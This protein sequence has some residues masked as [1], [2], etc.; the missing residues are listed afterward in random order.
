MGLLSAVVAG[1]EE[2]TSRSWHS[3]EGLPYNIVRSLAQTRDG[4]LWVGTFAGLAR[5]DGVRFTT[6]DSHNT[7]ALKS[8]NISALCTD[9]DGTLWIG[10]YGGGI[11]RLKDGVFTAFGAQ[12]GLIGEY[13]SSL[14]AARD[15]TIWIGTTKGVNRLRG[16]KF[17]HYGTNEGLGADIVRSILADSAGNVWI[18][19]GVGLYRLRGEVMDSFTIRNG[20]PHNSVRGLMQDRQGVLW[21]GSDAGMT[22]YDGKTFRTYGPAEG[23]TA[24]FV[25]NFC[26][27]QRGN[28][29]IGT[30][31]GTVRFK[32]GKFHDELS[33]DKEPFD[34][35][36]TLFED[37]EGDVWAGSREGLIRFIPKR[38]S[39]FTRREGLSDNNVLSVEEDRQGAVWAGTWGG[40]LDQLVDGTVVKNYS[41][42]NGYPQDLILSTCEARDGS[43]W[44]GADYDTGLVHIENGNITHYTA[45]NGLFNAAVRVLRE[46]KSGDLWI[47]T[48]QGLN[49]LH[50]GK[51][52]KYTVARNNLAGPVVRDICIDSKDRL[53]IA[54]E[55]GLSL[56]ENG[57]CTNFTTSN[58]LVSA[59]LLSV[60]EDTNGDL[61]L[62]SYGGGLE[63][64]HNGQFTS[65]AT[66][67]GM[68][69]DNAF[70]EAEDDGGNLW[71]SCTRGIV[72]VRKSDF[73]A[74]DRHQIPALRTVTY[75]R[76][77]GL[78]GLVC[79]N[80]SQPSVWKCRD[81]RILFPS[82]K[83]LVTVDA[84][85]PPNALPPPVVIEQLI[86]DNK[87][88]DLVAPSP[89]GPGAIPA[90]GPG[91]AVRIPPGRGGVEIHFTA[92]S[93]QLSEK[94]N[95][96][97]QL[98]GVDSGWVDAGTR[99]VAYYNN[100]APGNYQF[101]VTACNNDGVWSETP[102]T[103]SFE[104][105]P[106]LWQTPWFRVLA[107]VVLMGSVAGVVRYVS[108][109]KLQRQLAALEGQHA[110]EKERARIAR[111]IHD[112]LGA[113]LTQI[114]LLSD[115]VGE[116]PPDEAR[117][118]ARKISTTARDLAQSLDE[119]VWAVNPRHDTLEGLVE[120]ISQFSDDFLEDT[121]I[122]SR[123]KLPGRL[124]PC[125]IPAEARHQFFL[126]FKEALH[127]AV[128]HS[129]ATE[130]EI[131]ASA[132]GAEMQL[133]IIDNGAGFDPAALNGRGNGLKN[134]RQRL[135]RIGGRFNLASQPGQGTRITLAIRVN[136]APP[137]PL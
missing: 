88:M 98:D 104:L 7:P 39:T 10:T 4:Y 116:E 105:T 128:K 101:R 130:I 85:I 76:L 71:I 11:T 62:G 2:F 75:G 29:W 118:S 54:T 127:N 125:S 112:D 120:Y 55:D 32:D 131:A 122:R 65:Y 24:R 103:L 21:I 14:S 46:D 64:R 49:R 106:H 19:T 51:F 97:Y 121:A 73:D 133:Q 34:L 52:S 17:T 36:N 1:A 124:P 8:S 90:T 25:Q 6:F 20:L 80:T 41:S 23:L 109:R 3:D 107:A 83:G 31:S 44:V 59:Y 63:R 82:T 47:G 40:G 15:G 30:Y 45:K 53:W 96:K 114:A 37:R 72:R 79:N 81:G 132:D 126:A 111:D 42:R 9:G 18:S 84:S 43:L 48:S 13:I 89:L 86:I 115:R 91:G 50:R 58:G 27:D 22:S 60:N 134:M 69:S 16:G 78:T 137:P 33:T 70:D 117:G 110:I 56:M 35:V 99:R 74:Y 28:L 93:L 87:T 12:E 94:N 102:A 68:I 26:E 108:F 5:F 77:D 113:R 95:F 135:E 136:P 38:F 67:Q 119:I 123:L 129:G 92:L 57:R 61:W 100:V 66:A